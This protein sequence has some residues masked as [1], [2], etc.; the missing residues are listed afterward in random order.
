MEIKSLLALAS[1][2]F[3]GEIL[4]QTS[5]VDPEAILGPISPISIESGR[6]IV[7]FSSSGSAKFRKRDG[8]LV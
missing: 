1:F 6:Y 5:S 3:C 2:I 4:A 8:N 7:K